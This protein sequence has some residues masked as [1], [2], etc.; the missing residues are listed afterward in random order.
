MTTVKYAERHRSWLEPE[1]VRRVLFLCAISRFLVGFTVEFAIGFCTAVLVSYCGLR[2][3][4]Y[5][6]FFTLEYGDF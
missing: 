6:V 3:L 5:C 1:L 4:H 2:L